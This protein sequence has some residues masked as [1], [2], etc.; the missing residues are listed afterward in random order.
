MDLHYRREITVGA[1]VVVGAAAFIGG[2]LWLSGKSFS[3]QPEIVIQF[4][5]VETLKRGSPVKVSGVPMGT[6]QDIQFQEYGK[7]LV[8]ASL[9][10]RVLPKRDATATLA[11]TGLVADAVVNLNPGSA[12]EALPAGAVIPGS[13]ER[14]IMSSATDLTARA[15]TALAGITEIANKQLAEDLTRTLQAVQRLAAVYGDRTSGPTAEL[16]ATLVEFRQ[17]RNRL[18][19]TLTQLNLAGR[20]ETADTLMRNLSRLSS[21][22]GSTAARFDSV[23]AKIQR[24]EGT[25]GKFVADT[26]FYNRARETLRAVQE[27]VDDI[28][29]HPGKLGITVRIF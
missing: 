28:R 29:K 21:E 26:G 14:G 15:N 3:S 6:V 11:S 13:V 25:L 27:F 23:L 20:V 16:T 17:M 7:V 22:V 1:L 9:D 4:P 24:G 2:T 12:A 18:D 19:S 5:D 10:P 8:H